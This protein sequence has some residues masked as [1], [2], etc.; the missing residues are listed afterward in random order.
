LKSYL[1]R[2]KVIESPTCPCG[3]T[4]QTVDHLIF[5]CELLGK[6][7]DKLI[8][9]VEKT[10]NC[11]ISE[12]RLILEHFKSFSKFINEISLEKLNEM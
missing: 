1:H 7:R 12:N 4:E 8:S 6:E 10:D 5:Q 9:G 11:P 3:T 2:F